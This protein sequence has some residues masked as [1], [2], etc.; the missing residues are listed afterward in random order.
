MY[1]YYLSF[2]YISN[3]CLPDPIFLPRFPFYLGTYEEEALCWL[4]LSGAFF[5]LIIFFVFGT[6]MPAMS[7]IASD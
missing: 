3:L 4:G 2:Y 1:F 7:D 6:S 5:Y